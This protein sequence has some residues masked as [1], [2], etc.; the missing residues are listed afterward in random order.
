M[1][2]PTPAQ[3]VTHYHTLLRQH[4]YQQAVAVLL[5]VAYPLLHVG[6]TQDVLDLFHAL[7]PNERANY[8]QILILA[9]DAWR[10]RNNWQQAGA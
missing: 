10:L 3:Q 4:E 9:G 8:P 7:P 1:R 6:S 5:A 2:T